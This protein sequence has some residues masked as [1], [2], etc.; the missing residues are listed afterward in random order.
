M[1]VV[2][3]LTFA[4][5][6]RQQW[7]RNAIN[8]FVC[9]PGFLPS[10]AWRSSHKSLRRHWFDRSTCAVFIHCKWFHT[11]DT[12]QH[13]EQFRMLIGRIW[14]HAPPT[15]RAARIDFRFANWCVAATQPVNFQGQKWV[16]RLGPTI[17]QEKKLACTLQNVGTNW[18]IGI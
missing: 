16:N 7:V 13:N 17:T 1:R 14:F 5:R 18:S 9:R 8:I 6:R 15:K 3:L 2:G 4:V 10:T 11:A 12:V